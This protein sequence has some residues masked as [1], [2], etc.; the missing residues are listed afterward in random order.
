[1]RRE[2]ELGLID[3]L[4]GATAIWGVDP[5]HIANHWSEE[6]LVA[7]LGAYVRRSD[8]EKRAVG[9]TAGEPKARQL[10]A[11]DL[12]FGQGRSEVNL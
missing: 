8:R 2:R 10:T 6:F 3:A 7:M 9:D 12:G 1:M 5:L 4:E 11:R